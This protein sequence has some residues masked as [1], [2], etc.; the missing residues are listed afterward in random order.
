MNHQQVTIATGNIFDPD[1]EKMMSKRDAELKVLAQKN[2]K[3]FGQRGL[4]LLE[5][6]N[7]LNYIGDIK[8]GYETLAAEVF[9]HL[10]P[11]AHFPE[12]KESVDHL[13]EKVKHLD[14]EIN[15]KEAQNDTDQNA[16]NEFA[17]SHIPS[18]ILWAFISTL[19]IT[20]GDIMFNTKS[21]Q[22]TGENLLFALILS[23][24][25]SFSVFIFS[26]VAPM[27][28]K[29]AKNKLQR[30]IV[31]VG[32][33][34]LATLLFIALAI[35][36][37]SYLAIHD[38]HIQPFYFVIINL[39][40]FI[41]SALISFFVL[42]SWEEIKQNALLLKKHYAIKRR[43]KEIRPLKVERDKL[44]EAILKKKTI[45]IRITHYAN[46]AANRI[47]KMYFETVGIFK[48]I[49]IMFRP[50]NKPPDCYSVE[51]PFPDIDEFFINLITTNP[52]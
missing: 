45:C 30:I 6:D 2:A 5:G 29:V 42:P 46:Y 15:D 40:F 1:L 4:P 28:Y 51:V 8:A 48:T 11:D 52:K 12:A 47:K 17:Q 7:L 50:D 13:A 26:H 22:V 31:I 25:V 10:Q 38:V 34:S 9:Q 37:S 19:L 32:S 35:F 20:I 33:L 36:R 21:F 16:L 44:K 41:V 24:C 39:F 23:I 27:L 49:N 3:N 14:T 43:K 18:R